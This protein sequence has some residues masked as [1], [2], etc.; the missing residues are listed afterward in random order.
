MDTFCTE[1]MTKLSVEKK[2]F[3]IA[4]A[5]DQT[6]LDLMLDSEM[7]SITWSTNYKCYLFL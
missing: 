7:A 5:K 1:Y 6:P 4:S 2:Y 3:C